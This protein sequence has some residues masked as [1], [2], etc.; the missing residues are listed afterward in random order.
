MGTD[1]ELEK[2]LKEAM[3]GWR[4]AD[5]RITELEL[6][7]NQLKIRLEAIKA[8]NDVE[9]Y[10][11]RIKALE[12]ELEACKSKIKLQT[13]QRQITDEEVNRIKELR[14]EGMSYRAIEKATGWSQ[15]TINRAINGIYDQTFN[16]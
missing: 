5:K 1:K 3:R 10:K 6:E 7:N 12:A 11:K 13:K 16:I 8:D 9:A 2:N 15:C 14:A 4:E